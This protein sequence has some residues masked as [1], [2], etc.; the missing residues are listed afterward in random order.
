LG[1]SDSQPLQAKSNLALVSQAPQE[2]QI[3]SVILGSKNNFLEML[4]LL[5]FINNSFVWK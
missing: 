5:Q 1:G 3:I 2:G 4:Q